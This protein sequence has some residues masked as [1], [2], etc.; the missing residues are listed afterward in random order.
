MSARTVDCTVVCYCVPREE[1][2]E[3]PRGTIAGSTGTRLIKVFW[4]AVENL[5]DPNYYLDLC[6]SQS[7]LLQVS[8][9]RC[10]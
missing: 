6:T 4:D 5:R 3:I 10:Y 2:V 1:E 9:S 8:D 7:C